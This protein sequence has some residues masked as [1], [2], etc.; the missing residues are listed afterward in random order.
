M[1]LRASSLVEWIIGAE[2]CALL[3]GLHGAII[4]YPSLTLHVLAPLQLS[5]NMQFYLSRGAGNWRTAHD[6]SH[7]QNFPQSVSLYPIESSI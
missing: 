7:I 4:D 1:R 5:Q 3:Q 6:N 2:L